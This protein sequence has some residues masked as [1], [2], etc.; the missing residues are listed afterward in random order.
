MNDTWQTTALKSIESQLEANPGV[1]ALYVFGSVVNNSDSLD[2]WSDL[3]L[4]IVLKDD[5]I[6]Q[7]Y[8]KLDWL[9]SFGEIFGYEQSIYNNSYTTK[10]IF[11]NSIKIDFVFVTESKFN[12][13]IVNNKALRL[14]FSKTKITEI[15]TNLDDSPP[16]ITVPNDLSQQTNSFWYI[17]YTAL[18]KTSRNDL[19]IG[20][21][22]TLE[23]Y[24]KYLE[25]LMLKRDMK[26]NTNIH[27]I[28][29]QFNEKI[30]DLKFISK[31]KSKQEIVEMINIVCREFDHLATEL[32][33]NYIS[34]LST[35][36]TLISIAK[37][38][39]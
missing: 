9:S 29:G 12:R 8:P 39:I 33:S 18:S 36:N 24:K 21:H 26:L 7:F 27:R 22:L 25:L 23:L 17:A 10:V 5:S 32:D 13:E 4:M 28:G 31:I 38:R 11:E 14:I 35:A 19:L 6:S 3:D 34:K 20:L 30:H 37:Q 1:L 2:L 15:I 16:T